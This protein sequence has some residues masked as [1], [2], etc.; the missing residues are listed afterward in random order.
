[1]TISVIIPTYNECATIGRL[2]HELRHYDADRQVEVLVI[3]ANSPDG[4]AEVA[5][6]AGATVLLAPRPGRAVQMN[7]GAA[8]AA[9]AML[10]V[11][12]HDVVPEAQRRGNYGTASFSLVIG[13]IIM[14]V[15]DTAMG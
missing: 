12:C 1:M 10:Y 2:V 13:F 6:R 15:L 7:H 4:T 3:D 11:I 8:H 5:R 14:M 9:G